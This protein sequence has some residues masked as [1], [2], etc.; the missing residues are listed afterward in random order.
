[1]MKGC[2]IKVCKIA[3]GGSCRFKGVQCSG[4]SMVSSEVEG[5]GFRGFR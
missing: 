1:M 5:S 4:V 3:S 2:G